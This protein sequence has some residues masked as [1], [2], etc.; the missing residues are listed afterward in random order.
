MKVIIEFLKEKGTNITD[1]NHLKHVRFQ[2]LTVASKMFRIVSWDVLL[3]KTIVDRRFRGAYCLNHQ[4]R[5]SLANQETKKLTKGGV[6]AQDSARLNHSCVRNA[7][8][9]L[10]R[11]LR[12]SNWGYAYAN[13]FVVLAEGLD[14]FRLGLLSLAGI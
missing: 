5:V 1:I 9:D 11:S 8:L 7:K 2:V 10:K 4:G 3:C 13:G 6:L 12:Y 14:M